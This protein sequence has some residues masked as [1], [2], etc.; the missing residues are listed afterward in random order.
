MSSE[1]C[2]RR[3]H[4]FNNLSLP[5]SLAHSCSILLLDDDGLTYLLY[6]GIC[7]FLAKAWLICSLSV[8]LTTAPSTASV[9][10]QLGPSLCSSK[11]KDSARTCQRHLES[12]I[13]HHHHHHH[14]DHSIEIDHLPCQLS[15]TVLEPSRLPVYVV[16]T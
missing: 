13:N 5:P 16:R 8:T 4:I 2:T 1:T 9:V 3:W 11:V 12:N 7:S 6:Q 14:D 10:I 15:P